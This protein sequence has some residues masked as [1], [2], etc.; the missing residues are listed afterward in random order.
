VPIILCTG[1]SEKM[2]RERAISLGIQGFLMK[3]LVPRDV[4]QLIRRILKD[5]KIL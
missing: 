4:A 2:D 1:F 5:V 3:P